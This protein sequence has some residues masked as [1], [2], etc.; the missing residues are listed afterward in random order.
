MN[1]TETVDAVDF[2]LFANYP[3]PYTPTTTIKYDIAKASQVELVI[4]DVLGRRIKTVV[5]QV[6]DSGS[7]SV[8][9]DASQFASGVYFY[10]L[11]AKSFVVTKKMILLR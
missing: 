1:V 8:V 7:Y 6:Q 2:A 9:I 5:N 10:Q 4:Y 3:D 11:R